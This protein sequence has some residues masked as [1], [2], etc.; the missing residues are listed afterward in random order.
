MKD[1]YI[2]AFHG[3]VKET[4]ATT[5]LELP[6]NLEAY[7]VMLLANNMDK[8]DFLPERSFAEAYLKLRRPANYNAKE[9]GDACLFVSGAFPTYG[10]KYGL[11]KDYYQNIG[12]SSYEMVAEVMNFELFTQLSLHFMFLSSFIECV[13]VSEKLPYIFIKNI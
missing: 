8:P 11:S 6:E 13:V 1:E 5:G 7:I 3:V 10:Q 2:N 9:L 4:Q 12:I